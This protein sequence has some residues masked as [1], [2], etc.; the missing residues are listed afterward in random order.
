MNAARMPLY[1]YIR[2]KDDMEK[3]AI[4]PFKYVK[5]ILIIIPIMEAP[6]IH[7][8]SIY[9]V[10]SINEFL[11]AFILFNSFELILDIKVVILFIIISLS[12]SF[13]IT[14]NIDPDMIPNIIINIVNRFIFLLG[15][16]ILNTLLNFFFIYYHHLS[17]LKRD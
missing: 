12:P 3:P 4:K 11:K 15:R 6:N 2:M 9:M 14:K 17:I 5:N 16:M 10:F 7:I 1:L 8:M 13:N